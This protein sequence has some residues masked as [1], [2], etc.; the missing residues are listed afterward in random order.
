MLVVEYLDQVLVDSEDKVVALRLRFGSDDF[1]AAA[2]LLCTAEL[3]Q[4]EYQSKEAEPRFKN[5]LWQTRAVNNYRKTSLGSNLVIYIFDKIEAGRV[6]PLIQN[7]P[8]AKA[9]K[10]ENSDIEVVQSTRTEVG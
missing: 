4:P 6:L 5:S 2:L 1:Y 8:E 3:G 7:L 10:E 9:E